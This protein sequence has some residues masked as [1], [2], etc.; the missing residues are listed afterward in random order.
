[1]PDPAPSSIAV[2]G[3]DWFGPM[4]Q[5]DFPHRHAFHEIVYLAGGRGTH[6]ID[7]DEHEIHPPQLFVVGPGQVHHW[8]AASGL[9]GR[10]QR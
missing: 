9:R 5:A 2:G 1:M 3:F 8:R 4:A 7:L 10:G 6:V